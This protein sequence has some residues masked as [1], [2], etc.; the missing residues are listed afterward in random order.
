MI[1]STAELH[2][3]KNDFIY[4]LIKLENPK[5]YYSHYGRNQ[6]SNEIIFKTLV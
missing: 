4:G 5:S 6:S 1:M 2:P 3:E